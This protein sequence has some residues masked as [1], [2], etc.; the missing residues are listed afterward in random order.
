MRT[1]KLASSFTPHTLY[2]QIAGQESVPTSTD[3]RLMR[4]VTERPLGDVH[5]RG[6][7]RTTLFRFTDAGLEKVE[8][9]ELYVSQMLPLEMRNI[10]TDGDAALSLISPQLNKASKRDQVKDAIRSLLGLRLLE[11]TNRHLVGAQRKYNGQVA[12]K[13]AT[14]QAAEVAGRINTLET[15]LEDKADRL[16]SVERQ[17]R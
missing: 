13:D 11:V 1:A 14:G 12:S 15:D 2:D 3:Y 5:N 16:N 8:A 10:W 6:P 17:S 4:A 9:P 7:D